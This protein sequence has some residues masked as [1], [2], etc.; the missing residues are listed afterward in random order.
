MA[1]RAIGVSYC[2]FGESVASTKYMDEL[3][4]GLWFRHGDSPPEL[5]IGRLQMNK[6]KDI[7]KNCG[8]KYGVTITV[9]QI[10]DA[11]VINLNIGQQLNWAVQCAKINDLNQKDIEIIGEDGMCIVI[12]KPIGKCVVLSFAEFIAHKNGLQF[13]EEL[14]K[15]EEKIRDNSN[16]FSNL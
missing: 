11:I 7:N 6:N 9:L 16:Y 3:Y 12:F 8:I 2:L 10:N 4:K 13:N 5:R 1:K 14:S 15:I